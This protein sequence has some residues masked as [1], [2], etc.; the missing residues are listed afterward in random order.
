MPI[1]REKWSFLLLCLIWGSTWVGVKASLE[2]VP[3]LFLAGSRFTAAGLLLLG[4]SVAVHGWPLDRSAG[5]R[6]ALASM[7]II[8]V[9]YGCLFWGMVYVDSGTAAVLE[10]GLTPIALLAFALAMGEERLSR[11]RLLA[12]AL[13][14]A[15]LVLLFGSTAWREWTSGD[16][17]AGHRLL[18]AAAVASAA[19]T[20]SWG[21]VITRP[22]LRR[23]P[24]AIISGATTLIGG[25]VLLAV[26]L[27][28]EPGARAALRF[29]WGI[30][31]WSG[32][33][34][35]VIFGSLL[36]YT[37]YM[38][39]LRDIGPSRAGMYAF[40]SPVIAVVL[41][42]L[43]R[44]ESIGVMELAGMGVL[45][46]A[47]WLAMRTSEAPE[48]PIEAGFSALRERRSRAR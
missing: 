26:S 48:E 34:F 40:V 25:C 36:G 18:G 8:V 39:L 35:L 15:G 16:H 10:M 21:S 24:P 2:V 17:S 33:L 31:A 37:I 42:T 5:W 32:W 1:S 9:C 20:Y 38:R 12:I 45:L 23:Y 46:L 7:L 11:S 13:G 19:I 6:L 44:S 4:G 22:L 43:I 28:A 27:A 30:A 14:L 41:G 3:P 29:D 47:A